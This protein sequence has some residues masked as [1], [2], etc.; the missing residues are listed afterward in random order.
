MKSTNLVLYAL[1]LREGR[2]NLAG[3]HLDYQTV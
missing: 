1:E 3:F 2:G